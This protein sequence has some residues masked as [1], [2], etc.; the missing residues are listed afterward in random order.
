MNT[1]T[2]NN[3]H[4][5]VT[6]IE[7]DAYIGRCI[8]NGYEWDGWMRG[9]VQHFYKPG[10]DILDVG[11]NIGYNALMFSDYGPVHTFEPFFHDIISK[12][13]E[14]N[15]LKNS[16]TV[17]PYGL[18]SEEKSTKI[19]KPHTYETGKTNY[20][21]FSLHHSSQHSDTCYDCVVKRLDDIYQGPPSIIKVDIEGHE[22]EFLKGAKETIA[23]HKPVL[24]MEIH[25]DSRQHM[26]GILANMGYTTAYPRPEAVFIL[27]V[28]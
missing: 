5:T 8:A 22:E 9:D 16:V 19:Y 17:H 15:N 23:K 11:G 2:T 7:D 1:L 26:F 3:G 6:Y 20:G 10:T 12:N 13:V 4:Y 24:M 18:S 21:G 28:S 27:T 25:E 14:Q